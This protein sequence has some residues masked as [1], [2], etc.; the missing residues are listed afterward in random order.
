[1]QGNVNIPDSTITTNLSFRQLVLMNMQQLTNFPYIEKD[2]DALTDY[3]LLCLVVKY[4]NDVIANQNEQNNS[5][6]RMYESFLAL[7]DYVNNTKDELE[8]AFNNLDDYVRNYF[9]NLDVQDE[10]NNKLDQ[11]LED[12]VL[13]QIIEQFLQLTSLICFDNVADMKS[14]V[15]LANGSYAKTLGY[16]NINDDG[17]A[18]YKIRTI[19]NDDVVDEKFII[20]L[21]DNTLIAELIYNKDINMKQVGAYGDGTHDETTL[22][23]YIFNYAKLRNYQCN[24]IIPNGKYLIT[25]SLTL[26]IEKVN[27]IGQNAEIQSNISDDNPLLILIGGDDVAPNRRI[28]NLLFRNINNSNLTNSIAIRIGYPSYSQTDEAN[29]ATHFVINN[30]TFYSFGHCF[31]LGNNAYIFQ[32][33]KC[34]TWNCKLCFEDYNQYLNNSGENIVIRD[35]LFTSFELA[36]KIASSSVQAR[37]ENTSFDQ[38]LKVLEYHGTPIPHPC[39]AITFRDCH[40]ESSPITTPLFEMLSGEQIKLNILRCTSYLS[41]DNDYLIKT[42]DANGREFNINLEDNIFN[43]HDNIPKYLTNSVRVYS[44]NNIT[45]RNIL[46]VNPITSNNLFI[47]STLGN[48]VIN[49]GINKVN[50]QSEIVNKCWLL[51]DGSTWDLTTARQ[52]TANASVSLDNSVK[53]TGMTQSYKVVS[54]SAT[55]RIPYLAPITHTG[56]PLT[57][58][59]KLMIP[60]AM[61]GTLTIQ[62]VYYDATNIN[63][64]GIYNTTQTVINL[65]TLTPEEWN[66]INFPDTL[67]QIQ[68]NAKYVGFNFMLSDGDGNTTFH[69]ADAQL[70]NI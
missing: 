59:I 61:T 8:D 28:T 41:I 33:E 19:T 44:R 35:S 26:D 51:Y 15:N 42:G 5:I 36:I 49:N 55:A 20:A 45:P 66:T 60:S 17:G 70:Q 30:C 63:Q 37:F 24:I 53:P 67:S 38:G 10:I 69:F 58:S 9:D 25:D 29:P 13:E 31:I 54:T 1:M 18:T 62:P 22:F 16:H 27:L 52:S 7:Q 57:G 43:F 40:F 47:N 39:N 14:S 34:V 3:E 68:H 21:N 65:S 11:M 4:L 50:G 6:T 48:T 12:G 46:L 23:Q 32:I 56:T 2:F 64:I